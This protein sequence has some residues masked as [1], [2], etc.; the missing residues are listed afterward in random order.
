METCGPGFAWHDELGRC[1]LPK[2]RRTFGGHEHPDDVI[3][4]TCLETLQ[5]GG[6]HAVADC[7]EQDGA[8]QQPHEEPRHAQ[9]VPA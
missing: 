4:G 5:Q 3:R 6:Q 2:C 7:Q 1:V 8:N 9:A